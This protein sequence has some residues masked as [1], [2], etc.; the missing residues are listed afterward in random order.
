M[1]SNALNT[2]STLLRQ[3]GVIGAILIALPLR[4][5]DAPSREQIEFFENK[6]RPVLVDKCYSCHSD[7]SKKLKGELKVDSAAALLKGGESGSPAVV[8]G[9]PEQSKLI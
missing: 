9:H 1:L 5:A 6:I 7:Q 2:K 8:P 4:A 3:I